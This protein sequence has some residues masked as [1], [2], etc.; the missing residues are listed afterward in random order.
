MSCVQGSAPFVAFCGCRQL[1]K[2]P[3]LHVDLEGDDGERSGAQLQVVSRQATPLSQLAEMP[4][5]TMIIFRVANKR[6]NL[7]KR[8]LA[9]V[10]N[11]LP[12]DIAISLYDVLSVSKSGQQ[13]C[14]FATLGKALDLP[15]VQLFDTRRDDVNQAIL[16]HMQH[17]EMQGSVPLQL[18]GDA[19]CRSREDRELLKD[20]LDARAVEGTCKTFDV[21]VLSSSDSNIVARL[22]REGV[23]KRCDENKVVLNKNM[24]DSSSVRLHQPGMV[25]SLVCPEPSAFM[26]CLFQNMC[27]H[28]GCSEVFAIRPAVPFD[29]SM[30]TKNVRPTRLEV[31]MKLQQEGWKLVDARG[32]AAKKLEPFVPGRCSSSSVL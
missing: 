24:L 25:A 2:A 28:D 27:S 17:W 30:I 16:S 22:V 12:D 23:L 32:A 6:P 5:D 15:L 21:S 31:H 4:D 20:V 26:S 10:D 7:R 13:T 29:S 18:A 11:V 3:W 8:P 14:V 19:A 1:D 9:S